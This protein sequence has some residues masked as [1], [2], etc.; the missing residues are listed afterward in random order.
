MS[1]YGFEALASVISRLEISHVFGI[2]G[3]DVIRFATTINET[4]AEF[5]NARHENQA[6]AMAMG[7]AH[8]GSRIGLAVITGGPGFT[9][10]LTAINTAARTGSRVMIVTGQS[11]LAFKNFP[12]KELCAQIG[13]RVL[14]VTNPSDLDEPFD[15]LVHH[16]MLG[17]VS[18]VLLTSG[19]DNAEVE[20]EPGQGQLTEHNGSPEP[21]D[22]AA[23]RAD[24]SRL[25]DFLELD[26]AAS[27]PVILGGFG[28]LQSEAE[29]ELLELAQLLGAITTTTLRS[30]GFLGS[31]PFHVGI[32]GTFSSPL[33][34]S[35][36]AEADCLLAFGASLNRFTTYGNSLFGPGCAMVQVDS[37]VESIGRF[38]PIEEELS[39]NWDVRAFVSVLLDELK[40][41]G[42]HR[43]GFRT[44]ELQTELGTYRPEVESPANTPGLVDLRV[45]AGLLSDLI[46]P[47]RNIVIDG[48]RQATYMIPYLRPEPG[49]F[50]LQTTNGGAIGL[51]MGA[52]IG[53]SFARPDAVTLLGIGDTSF[54]MSVGDLDTAVRYNLPIVVVLGNDEALG[55]EE[56]Y[57]EMNG[58]TSDI[59]KVP[60]PS[61]VDVS[62]A[63]GARV[64]TIRSV[65]DI[66]DIA[67]E[68]TSLS[69]GPVVLEC[70]LDVSPPAT[71]HEFAFSKQ[72]R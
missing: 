14:E 59:V 62:K 8:F 1:M 18:V 71:S 48:G 53:A 60:S 5:V 44:P 54:L 37:N 6:V 12:V 47:V 20:W 50:F 35:L 42:V 3:E 28:A 10:A 34:T 61:L 33:A 25:A 4:D 58:I 17:N 22:D 64:F 40:S 69:A 38:V 9:N 29:N 45:V 57:L 70:H 11:D 15:D 19:F 56:V 67:S 52:A 68:L 49:R 27:K 65:E 13:I 41:R 26:W 39:F 51:S 72:L 30:P 31:D 16:T 55:S 2:P 32:C 63:F 7:Y 46:P 23:M 43:Q 24:A 36:F 21:L 66:H